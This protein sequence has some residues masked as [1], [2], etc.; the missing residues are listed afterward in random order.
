MNPL[1][2][3]APFISG[4]QMA[5]PQPMIGVGKC[6]PGTTSL[7]APFAVSPVWPFPAT[8]LMRIVPSPRGFIPLMLAP[9]KL[10]TPNMA[11]NWYSGLIPGAIKG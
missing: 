4:W 11:W 5:P 3:M 2:G 10:P 8:E 7:P 9:L 6:N 1:S